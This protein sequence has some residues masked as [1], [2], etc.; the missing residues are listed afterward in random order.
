MRK[1]RGKTLVEIATLENCSK[2][3]DQTLSWSKSQLDESG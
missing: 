1:S 3:C 2:H